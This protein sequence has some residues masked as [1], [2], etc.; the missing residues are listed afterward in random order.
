MRR[1][2]QAAAWM[3]HAAGA[4][5]YLAAARVGFLLAFATQRVRAIWPPTGI[6]VVTLLLG[7]YRAWPGV[8]VGAF[9]ANAFRNEPAVTAAGIAA[10]NTLEALLGVYLLRRFVGF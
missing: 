8:F 4:L 9:L 6:A 1:R 10:G 3:T 2:P 5:R 7:G